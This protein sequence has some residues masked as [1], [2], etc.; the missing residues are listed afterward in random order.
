MSEASFKSL[1]HFFVDKLILRREG[2][3]EEYN[4]FLLRA[5]ALARSMLVLRG[6]ILLFHGLYH[7]FWDSECCVKNLCIIFQFS[8]LPLNLVPVVKC[9]F[10]SC[11]T[12]N[13]VY[14]AYR[15]VTSSCD[16]VIQK[17][18]P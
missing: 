10:N 1:V 15:R 2:G 18:D 13:L 3:G 8:F 11:L 17:T 5:F 9:A 14:L 7:F 16:E 4:L 12:F 6:V